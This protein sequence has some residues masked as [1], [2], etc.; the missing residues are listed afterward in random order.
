MFYVTLSSSDTNDFVFTQNYVTYKW[1]MHA[2]K[3]SAMEVAILTGMSL[4][5]NYHKVSL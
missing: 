2:F 4:S 3:F 5:F 1:L